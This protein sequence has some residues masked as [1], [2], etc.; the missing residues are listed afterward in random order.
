M[1]P[2]QYYVVC[3]LQVTVSSTDIFPRLHHPVSKST[4]LFKLTFAVQIAVH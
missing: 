4:E 1:G 2:P 3:S